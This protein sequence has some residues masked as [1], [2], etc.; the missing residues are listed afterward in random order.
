MRPGVPLAINQRAP[1]SPAPPPTVQV[2]IGRIEVRA[3]L[4]PAPAPQP[5]AR[6]ATPRLSLTD[7]L[8]QHAGEQR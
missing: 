3:I 6:P 5:S 1:E 2:T 4:P 8:K 7:Y